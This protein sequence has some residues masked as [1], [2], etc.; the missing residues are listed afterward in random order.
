AVAVAQIEG[1]AAGIQ[2]VR[3][4]EDHPTLRNYY[5]LPATLGHLFARLGEWEVATAYFDRAITLRCSD[6]EKRFLQKQR[7]YCETRKR[8]QPTV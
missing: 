4:I 8:A 7:R 6:P 3:G 2:I 5:L 1:P